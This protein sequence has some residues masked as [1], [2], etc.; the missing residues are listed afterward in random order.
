M[1][2]S[3]PYEHSTYCCRLCAMARQVST[4]PVVLVL[5]FWHSTVFVHSTA[6]FLKKRNTSHGNVRPYLED[7]IV[8]WAHLHSSQWSRSVVW[9]GFWLLDKVA[10]KKK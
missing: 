2:M 4:A 7:T 5:H 6:P 3:W 1:K 10:I 8:L 9:G